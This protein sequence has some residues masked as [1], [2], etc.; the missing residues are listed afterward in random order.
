MLY[1]H[2]CSHNFLGLLNG[3]GIAVKVLHRSFVAATLFVE[4]GDALVLTITG[5]SYVIRQRGESC[6]TSKKYQQGPFKFAAFNLK[7]TDKGP[8][9]VIKGLGLR[10]K[11]N[12]FALSPPSALF[13]PK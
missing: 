3:V 11:A 2:D 5:S 7:E 13:F 10:D 12:Y 8:L 4:M 9:Q 1:I 6:S